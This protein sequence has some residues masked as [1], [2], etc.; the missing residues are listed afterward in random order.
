[1]VAGTQQVAE[2]VDAAVAEKIVVEIAFVDENTVAVS[3]ATENRPGF[4]FVAVETAGLRFQGQAAEHQH[5]EVAKAAVAAVRH[6]D[7]AFVEQ[8]DVAVAKQMGFVVAAEAAEAAVMAM[9][10]F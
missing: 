3:A 6:I 5:A 8:I 2:A 1:M 7:F 10:E 4:P 9:I